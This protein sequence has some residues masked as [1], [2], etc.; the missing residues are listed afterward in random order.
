MTFANFLL[1]IMDPPEHRVY[2][3]TY[4][5][6]LSLARMF[7]E[8]PAATVYMAVLPGVLGS[9]F[10]WLRTS[11]QALRR[12]LGFNP[13]VPRDGCQVARP[14]PRSRETNS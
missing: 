8:S 1:N 11:S 7:Y 12:T 10:G 5:L 9:S 13:A 6:D 3:L 4:F 14:S 2:E